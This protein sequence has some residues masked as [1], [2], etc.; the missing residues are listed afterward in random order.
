MMGNR[1]LCGR[2][3][4]LEKVLIHQ[5]R[6]VMMSAALMHALTRSVSVQ[7]LIESNR[8]KVPA[9]M[10][11]VWGLAAPAERSLSLARRSDTP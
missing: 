7:L 6:E 5:A 8:F 3:Q 4:R 11:A 9:L 1:P 2:I 10:H